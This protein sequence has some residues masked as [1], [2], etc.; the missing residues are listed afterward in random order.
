MDYLIDFSPGLLSQSGNVDEL[1]PVV[2]VAL[3]VVALDQVLDLRFD[4]C[5]LGLEHGDIAHDVGLHLLEP[6][7]LLCFHHLDDMCLDHKG[8]LFF[9]ASSLLFLFFRELSCLFLGLLF[10]H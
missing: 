2:F 6:I 4:H 9:D 1:G 7:L 8:A 3:H 5:R 10:R